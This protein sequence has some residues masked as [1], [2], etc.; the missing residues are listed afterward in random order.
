MT[1]KDGTQKM[2]VRKEGRVNNRGAV[3][4]GFGHKRRC[5]GGRGY[6]G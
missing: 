2:T 5:T 6:G 4:E 1:G 3:E